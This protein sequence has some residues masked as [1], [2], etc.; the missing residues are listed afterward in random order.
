MESVIKDFNCFDNKF[1]DSFYALTPKKSDVQNFI[2]LI[3]MA[4]KM[5]KEIPIIAFVYIRRILQKVTGSRIT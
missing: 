4:G 1:T 2:E 3:M 5:E